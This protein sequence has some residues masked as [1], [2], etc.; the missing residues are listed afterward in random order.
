VCG[1]DLLEAGLLHA[2]PAM[3]RRKKFSNKATAVGKARGGGGKFQKEPCGDKHDDDRDDHG[4]GTD[5]DEFECDPAWFNGCEPSVNEDDRG[6]ACLDCGDVRC[7]CTWS[8]EAVGTNTSKLDACVAAAHTAKHFAAHN[9]WCLSDFNAFA[10]GRP[11]EEEEA[12]VRVRQGNLD[13]QH[14]KRR[15]AGLQGSAHSSGGA[16]RRLRCQAFVPRCFA[17]PNH[18]FWFMG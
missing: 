17:V 13:R 16:P 8:E 10:Q 5:D 4:D 14:K 6:S 15:R 1:R 12:R 11:Q 3:P 2:C 18:I 9:A 7:V